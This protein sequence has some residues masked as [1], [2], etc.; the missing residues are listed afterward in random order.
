MR[1]RKKTRKKRTRERKGRSNGS[2]KIGTRYKSEGKDE[3][4]RNEIN[5]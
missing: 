2:E 5:K 4:R 1:E 3:E